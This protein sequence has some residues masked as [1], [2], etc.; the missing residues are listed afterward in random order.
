MA[1]GVSTPWAR[2][3]PATGSEWAEGPDALE[4]VDPSLLVWEFLT[5]PEL[6]RSLRVCTS[7]GRDVTGGSGY[8]A[9]CK[10]MKWKSVEGPASSLERMHPLCPQESERLQGLQPPWNPSNSNNYGKVTFCQCLLLQGVVPNTL[11]N[12]QSLPHQVGMATLII[13]GCCI[14]KF[15]YSLKCICR[16]QVGSCL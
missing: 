10:V 9:D 16:P 5:G 15:T 7:Q 13:C 14:C 4:H 2:L 3:A 1:F 8:H 12:S 11:F 6:P